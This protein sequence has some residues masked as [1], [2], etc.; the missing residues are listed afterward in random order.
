M[1]V[2]N[3]THSQR[4]KNPPSFDSKKLA[5][6]SNFLRQ[7]VGEDFKLMIDFDVDVK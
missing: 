6:F 5:N 7:K 1:P 2:T 4:I 3:L